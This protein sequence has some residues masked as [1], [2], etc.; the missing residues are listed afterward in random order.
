MRSLP[1][2][3][4]RRSVHSSEGTQ[5]ILYDLQNLKFQVLLVSLG[6]RINYYRVSQPRF[7]HEKVMTCSICNPKAGAG[8]AMEPALRLMQLKKIVRRDW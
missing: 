3:A 7:C 6:T 5:S 2:W 1:R 8:I 4:C